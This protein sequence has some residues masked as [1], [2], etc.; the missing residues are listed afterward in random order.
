MCLPEKGDDAG[1]E[2]RDP[3]QVRVRGDGGQLDSR[4]KGPSG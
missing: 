4:S 2:E 3:E 1:G